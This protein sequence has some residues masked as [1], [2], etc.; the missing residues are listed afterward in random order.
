MKNLKIALVWTHPDIQQTLIFTLIKSLIKKKIEI[1]K[2]SK[3][4][5]I[6]YGP[7]NW[8]QRFFHFYR[9]LKRKIKSEKIKEFLEKFEMKQINFKK[10]LYKPLTIFHSFEP[11]SHDYIKADFSIT[12][13]LGV[14]SPYHLRLNDWKDTID[15]SQDG[16]IR[17][18]NSHARRFGR[19]FKIE[20]L[21]VPQG[22]F[23]LN[24]PRKMCI[25]TSHMT[26]P[27]KI[28]YESFLRNFT[29]DG[30]GHWFNNKVLNAD[31]ALDKRIEVLKNYA[32]DL[33]P[34]NTLVPGFVT[35]RVPEAYVAKSLPI[36][37]AD[38]NINYDFNKNAFINLNEHF[39]NNF[40]NV[41]NILKDENFLKKFTC[42]PLILEKPNIEKETNFVK[43]IISNF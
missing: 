9:F 36:T 31:S 22:N 42:E 33:C 15:W 8:D 7:Y 41:I 35:T 32:F 23:F 19:Y 12:H 14:N 34:E 25:F 43:K 39:Y 5:L 2:T 4:D 3:A 27:R 29:I 10:R 11:L 18:L 38:N 13:H 16:I 6:I 28:I 24:K 20:E 17:G 26:Q 40:T 21:L 37:W 1:T 30:Y